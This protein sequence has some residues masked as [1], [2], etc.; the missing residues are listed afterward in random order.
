MITGHYVSLTYRNK[1]VD[2]YYETAGSGIPLVCLHTAGADSRQYHPLMKTAEVTDHFQ[3]LAF[4]LPC[5]GRSM[6]PEGWWEEEYLLTTNDYVDLIFQFLKAAGVKQPIMMGCSMGGSILLEL[7][8]REPQMF[9]AFLPLESAAKTP[10]RL[11]D[12]LYHPQIH[13]GEM[14]AE[15]VYGTMAPQSPVKDRKDIWW[16]YSQS[17]P[18][19]YYGDIY[20]YSEEWDAREKLAHIDTNACPIY[21]FTG[22]YDYSC[23]PEMTEET[24]AQIKGAEI[25]IMKQLGHFPMSENFPLFYSYIKPVLN[26]FKEG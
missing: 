21:F 22:E 25:C 19:I 7:A 4:D 20:F 10:G 2:V 14:C 16:I 23:T 15:N 1:S 11:N 13:G 9:R 17:A 8:C 26:Q 3:V 6:P 5:H 24:A 18:G 12:Y